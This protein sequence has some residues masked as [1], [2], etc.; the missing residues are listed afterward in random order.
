MQNYYDQFD[1]CREHDI[2]MCA[3][4]CPFRI[5]ILDL[6][7]RIT[8]KRFNAAYKSIRDK[9]TFP[10]IVCRDLSCLLR[11]SLHTPDNR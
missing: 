3:D 1:A 11:E 2:P 4:A 5:D 10:A 8:K 7:E 6:Q 9:V